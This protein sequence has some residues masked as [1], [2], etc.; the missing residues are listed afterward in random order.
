M[1]TEI[2]QLR[3]KREYYSRRLNLMCPLTPAQCALALEFV[4]QSKQCSRE[5]AEGELTRQ[6]FVWAVMSGDHIGAAQDFTHNL[7]NVIEQAGD[8]RNP[9]N[10]CYIKSPE[11]KL[12]KRK[13]G[14]AAQA[15]AAAAVGTATA[16]PAA[17]KAKKTA[18][19]V[20]SSIQ[21]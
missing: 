18:D 21:P 4:M 1:E 15:A 11:A 8:L 17:K 19:K 3:K 20:E 14:A 13:A 5:E 2:D 12:E 7:L 10:E 6:R 16:Q 9:C